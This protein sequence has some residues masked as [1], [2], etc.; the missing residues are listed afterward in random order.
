MR[1]W[2]QC[3]HG[4]KNREISHDR[5]IVPPAVEGFGKPAVA[6]FPEDTPQDCKEAWNKTNKPFAMPTG[7]T[8]Y[9]TCFVTTYFRSE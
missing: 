6:F 8:P 9:D 1:E 4:K 3:F 7:L 5:S 2:S